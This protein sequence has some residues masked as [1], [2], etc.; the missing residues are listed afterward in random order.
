MSKMSEV[1]RLYL[2]EKRYESDL[3]EDTFLGRVAYSK[4][5]TDQS[6][7]RGRQALTCQA[8]Q[9]DNGTRNK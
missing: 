5:Y 7:E 1:Y 4:G 3:N 8:K 9:Q 6:N 2:E